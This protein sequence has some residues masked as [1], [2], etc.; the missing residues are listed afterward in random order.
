[1]LILRSMSVMQSRCLLLSEAV[2]PEGPPGPNVTG[3]VLDG[4]SFRCSVESAHTAEWCEE[5]IAQRAQLHICEQQQV[6]SDVGPQPHVPCSYR[7]YG[8]LLWQQHLHRNHPGGSIMLRLGGGTFRD[9]LHT[10]RTSALGYPRRPLAQSEACGTPGLSTEVFQSN[11]E[12]ARDKRAG[13][14]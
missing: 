13:P 12:E 8:W 7:C 11:L 2:L 4:A 9:Y 10:Q 14:S 1:M 3:A 5:L 6:K